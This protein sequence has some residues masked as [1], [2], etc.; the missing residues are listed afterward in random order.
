[1]EAF[2]NGLKMGKI[3]LIIAHL[4]KNEVSLNTSRSQSELNGGLS[5]K[6]EGPTTRREFIAPLYIRRI[7]TQLDALLQDSK[8]HQ[9][10]KS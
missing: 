5:E 3:V 1:M 4:H 8:N 2:C 10:T 6:P 9:L 7:A